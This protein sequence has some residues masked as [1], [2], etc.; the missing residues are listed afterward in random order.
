MASPSPPRDQ[1]WQEEKSRGKSLRQQRLPSS[2][3]QP[4]CRR[5]KASSQS[6]RSPRTNSYQRHSEAPRN[7][8]GSRRLT[9]QW[10]RYEVRRCRP[11]VSRTALQASHGR[12][13]ARQARPSSW[14]TIRSLARPGASTKPSDSSAKSTLIR[15]LSRTYWTFPRTRSTLTTPPPGA[16]S[17]KQ[18]HL[19]TQTPRCRRC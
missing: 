16:P 11:G 5:I 3:L 13:R 7:F 12:A 17:R 19:Q 4:R 6:S 15:K 2:L 18:Q 14:K 10:S 8:K 9:W 1:L